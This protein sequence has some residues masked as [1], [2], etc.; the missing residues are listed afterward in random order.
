MKKTMRFGALLFAVVLILQTINISTVLAYGAE[1][2]ISST[3]ARHNIPW[4]FV[5]YASPDFR[6]EIKGS[7]NAQSV[8]LIKTNDDGWALISTYSGNWWVYLIENIRF[9][10]QNTAV[11]ESRG[12]RPVEF[13]APQTVRILAQ[14]GNWLQVSTWLGSRWIYWHTAEHQPGRHLIPWRFITYLEPDSRAKKQETLLPQTVD[15]VQIRDDGWALIK[16]PRGDRWIYW[17]E[18]MRYVE[19]TVSLYDSVG[20]NPSG[21]I[22]PEVIS[23]I[24]QDGD[25]LQISTRFGPRWIHLPTTQQPGERRIALTFDD[26]PSIYT[27]RLLDELASR[28]VSATFFVLGQHVIANPEAARRIVEEGHEIASHSYSHPNFT[29]MNAAG[30]RSELNRTNDAILQATGTT[31]ALLRTPYGSYN[32]TVLSVAA[33]FGFPLI[34]WSVDTRDWESRNVSAVM[35]HFADRNYV[36]IKDGDIILLHDI[37]S[38]TIDAA[39]RAVDLLLAEGFTFVTVSE[40]LGVRYG[41]LTPGKVYTR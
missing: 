33:E 32:S 6:A 20:G 3:L 15:V 25:W 5:V 35:S 12:G 13:L 16:T 38:T 10:H 17:R 2:G 39:I 7:F 40:L 24:A 8:S 18:N 31:P 21:E 11:Y 41:T 36:K 9:L 26:G 29:N 23:I 37:Y 1:E 34:M 4:A 19:K 28:G 30:I 22:G 27:K 14:E